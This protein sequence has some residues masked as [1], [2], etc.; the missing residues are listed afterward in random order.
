MPLLV[1]TFTSV[2]VSLSF[3]QV[4]DNVTVKRKKKKKKSHH[5]PLTFRPGPSHPPSA[6]IHLYVR[7]GGRPLGHF[8]TVLGVRFC[9]ACAAD[10]ARARNLP[11]LSSLAR[12][13]VKTARATV[14]TTMA[15]RIPKYVY[16]LVIAG[17][18]DSEYFRR[19]VCVCVC[20]R[21]RARACVRD[22]QCVCARAR[23]CVRVCV[24]VCGCAR[25]CVTVNVL[26]LIHI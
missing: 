25:T 6:S 5:T 13:L 24:C 21:A 15:Q 10:R 14:R 26:S 7:H 18:A 22:C 23:A 2:S 20:A 9:G 11:H 17:P 12:A 19:C 3:S 4:F 8:P 16:E 1:F